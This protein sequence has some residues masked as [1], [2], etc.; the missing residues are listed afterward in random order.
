MNMLKI[1][2]DTIINIDINIIFNLLNLFFYDKRKIIILIIIG[3][4]SLDN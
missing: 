3:I 2:V 1:K 4:C